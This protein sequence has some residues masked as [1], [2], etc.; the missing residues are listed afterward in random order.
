MFNE[1][2]TYRKKHGLPL[3]LDRSEWFSTK[4]CYCGTYVNIGAKTMFRCPHCGWVEERDP[5]A[6]RIHLLEYIVEILKKFIG[7]GSLENRLERVRVRLKTGV[8]GGGDG[9]GTG[10]GSG[11]G[12]GGGSGGGG[13]GGGGAKVFSSEVKATSYAPGLE[14]RVPRATFDRSS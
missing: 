5:K 13:G 7:D 14:P 2:N 6:A 4:M 9:G 12:S 3:A 1:L 11:V 10:S 8:G